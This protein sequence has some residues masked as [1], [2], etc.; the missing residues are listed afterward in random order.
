[1]FKKKYSANR[2]ET[3]EQTRSEDT[4]YSQAKTTMMFEELDQL[5]ED[6][7]RSNQRIIDHYNEVARSM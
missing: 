6:L 4:W 2:Y 3:N 5:T 1:M 7:F